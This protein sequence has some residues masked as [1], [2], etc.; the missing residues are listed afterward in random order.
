MEGALLAT[1]LKGSQGHNG[2]VSCL[3]L[4]E[5]WLRP[6]GADGEGAEG[7]VGVEVPHSPVSGALSPGRPTG[8]FAAPAACWRRAE[9]VTSA[10]EYWVIYSPR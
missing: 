8:W 1:L 2:S 3:S 10:Q 4:W 5:R 6:T 9:R 7:V